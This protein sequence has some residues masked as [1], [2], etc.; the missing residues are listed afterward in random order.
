VFLDELFG[1]PGRR[2]VALAVDALGTEIDAAE[3]TALA[4]AYAAALRRA[5]G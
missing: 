1:A 2:G 3:I 5:A 4:P